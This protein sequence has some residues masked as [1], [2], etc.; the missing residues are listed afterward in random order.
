MWRVSF[1]DYLRECQKQGLADLIF[2][3]GLHQ[4]V[5]GRVT[6]AKSIQCAKRWSPL[7]VAMFGIYVRFRGG[8]PT[9]NVV[10]V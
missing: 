9:F 10:D 1:T 5:Q 2:V 6:M 7:N 3:P 4:S 8:N